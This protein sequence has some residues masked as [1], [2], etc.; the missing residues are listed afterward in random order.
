MTAVRREH[1][2]PRLRSLSKRVIKSCYGCKR[3]QA[4]AF[5]QAPVGNLPKN[6]T[7]GSWPFQVI[8]I[9][10][11]RPITY[12]A[13]KGQEKKSY[14]LLDACSLSPALY[15]ELLPDLNDRRVYSKSKAIYCKIVWQFNLS[16][17]PK[18]FMVI[19]CCQVRANE[20]GK[21]LL[22]CV[23]DVCLSS[24]FFGLLYLFAFANML[25]FLL[26]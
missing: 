3:H 26:C 6:T 20:I 5:A 18:E 12:R 9:D 21:Y 14:I 24:E 15:L 4:S 10:Y 25:W 2:I 13:R 11:A 19:L 1:W 8:G 7:K 16:R 17:A 23:S 22:F